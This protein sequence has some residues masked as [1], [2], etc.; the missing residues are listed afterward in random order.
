MFSRLLEVEFLLY[1]SLA[2]LLYRRNQD[3]LD[4]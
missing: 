3:V 1:S 4:P 2:L